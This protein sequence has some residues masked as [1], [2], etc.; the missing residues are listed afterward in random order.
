MPDFLETGLFK[1]DILRFFKFSKSLLLM[2]SWIFEIA[3]FLLAIWVERVETQ[4]HAKF[5][6][7]RSIGCKDIRFFDFSRWRPPSS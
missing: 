6:Q 5:R 7:N 2:L 3:K 1:A 4:Q